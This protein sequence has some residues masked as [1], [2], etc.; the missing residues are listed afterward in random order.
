MK[1][2]ISMMIVGAQK[3]GT[4]SLNNYMSQHPRIYTHFTLEFSLFNRDHYDKG[5]DYYFE[6]TIS[7]KRKED[8]ACYFLGKSVGLMYKPDLLKKLKEENPDVQIVI[9]LRNPVERAFSAFLFCEKEGIEPY[10]NFDD[11]IFKN[12][13]SR[14]NGEKPFELACDYIGRSGYLSHIKNILQIFP[15]E[16]V[17]FFLFEK[18]IKDLNEDLNQMTQVLGLPSFDFD[19]TIQYNKGK[20]TR[21]KTMAKL[22]SPGKNFF[23]KDWISAKKRMQLKQFLKKFNSKEKAGKNSSINT[24]TRIYLEKIFKPELPELIRLTGL[25][26]NEY[27]KE[28]N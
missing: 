23:A 15:K 9:V 3:A 17:H 22:L 16:N 14:F 27:W 10:K 13:I 5:F 1:N 26:L 7:D 25:P 4:T 12:D 11:A 8:P 19:T 21:S 24:E 6:K 20:L 28:L 18:M 2:K